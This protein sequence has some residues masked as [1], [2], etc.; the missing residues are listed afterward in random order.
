MNRP[1]QIISLSCQTSSLS[2]QTRSWPCQTMHELA[3]SDQ[4]L[5]LLLMGGEAVAVRGSE[6]V[7][8]PN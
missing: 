5:A 8:V 3:V 6:G 1:C 7:L 4:E 2:C